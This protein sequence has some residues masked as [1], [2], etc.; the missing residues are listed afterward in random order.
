MNTSK[1]CVK[2]L[3]INKNIYIKGLKLETLSLKI[4]IIRCYNNYKYCVS[5]VAVIKHDF[6]FHPFIFLPTT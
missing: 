1:Q 2:K 4:M 3:K 5:M 6:L